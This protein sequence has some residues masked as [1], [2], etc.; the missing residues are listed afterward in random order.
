M[1]STSD[2]STHEKLLRKGGRE[3]GGNHPREARL[4]WELINAILSLVKNELLRDQELSGCVVCF[5]S[6]RRRKPAQAS[7][8]KPLGVRAAKRDVLPGSH[9][10]CQPFSVSA[11]LF[12]DNSEGSPQQPAVSDSPSIFP[13][14]LP[15]ARFLSHKRVLLSRSLCS[16]AV[17]SWGLE[18]L[19]AKAAG[20]CLGLQTFFFSRHF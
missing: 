11:V 15:L 10:A 6:P 17:R 18:P 12:V 16:K 13:V 8:W 19:L 14:S 4:L 3:G 7:N 9:R 1:I 2:V 5:L 20:G